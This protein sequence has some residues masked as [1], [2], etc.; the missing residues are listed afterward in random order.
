MP[1]LILVAATLVALAGAW[2]VFVGIRVR[3][4]FALLV[5]LAVS[6]AC[7]AVAALFILGPS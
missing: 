3:D 7:S 6:I 4:W 2:A 1:L 5:G